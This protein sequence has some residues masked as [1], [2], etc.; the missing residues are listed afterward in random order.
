M[1]AEALAVSGIIVVPFLVGFVSRFI[2]SRKTRYA[3][4]AMAFLPV[5]VFFTYAFLSGVSALTIGDGLIFLIALGI[6]TLFLMLGRAFGRPFA[7]IREERRR[8][9]TTRTFE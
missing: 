8:D 7:E 9:R 5:A 2:A 1:L 6:C 4:S 3:V